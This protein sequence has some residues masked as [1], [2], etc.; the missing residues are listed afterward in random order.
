MSTPDRC[1]TR[2]LERV[3]VNNTVKP[4]AN[5]VNAVLAAAGKNFSLL[6]RWPVRLFERSD[7]HASSSRAVRAKRMKTPI[8][9]RQTI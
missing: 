4:K 1:A 9:A 7:P 2:D 8:A 3:V 5:R 6:P